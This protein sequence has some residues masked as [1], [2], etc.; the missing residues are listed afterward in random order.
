M[1]SLYGR[2]ILEKSRTI[3]RENIFKMRFL[4]AISVQLK[5]NAERNYTNRVVGQKPRIVV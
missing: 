5:Q 2:N 4:P 1:V 3:S